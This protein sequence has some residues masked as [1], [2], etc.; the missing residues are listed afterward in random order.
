MRQITLLTALLLSSASHSEAL[1]LN[2]AREL[3]DFA[4]VGGGFMVQAGAY[5]VW[6]S[7][8]RQEHR[9]HAIAFAILTSAVVA[10]TW[11]AKNFSDGD[12]K[13]TFSG[14]DFGM[15]MLGTGAA[16]ATI[17]TFGF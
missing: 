9:G 8:F 4:H 5:G 6:K 14:H 10:F 17:L 16:T 13:T 15:S 11:E 12:P 3:H 1:S 2:E 7:L